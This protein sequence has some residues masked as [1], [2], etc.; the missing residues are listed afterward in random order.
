MFDGMMD[1]ASQLLL[2]WERFGPNYVIDPVADYTRLTFDTIALCGMNY[3][4]VHP[5]PYENSQA[6]L[7]EQHQLFLSRK[8][9]Q[10][11]MLQSF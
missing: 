5:A 8:P 9:L 2:K 6:R 10:G 11:L 3:R 4:Y 1:I 7:L